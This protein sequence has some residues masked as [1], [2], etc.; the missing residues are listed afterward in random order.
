M[1]N[2]EPED[3]KSSDLPGE[4]GAAYELSPDLQNAGADSEMEYG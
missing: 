4:N 1:G 3:L 2:F